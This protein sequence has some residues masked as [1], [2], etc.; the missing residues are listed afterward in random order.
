MAVPV[1]KLTE[2]ILALPADER[3]LLADRLVES[4]DPLTDDAVRGSWASEAARRRDEVRS[5]K[6][7]AISGEAAA[8]QVRALLRK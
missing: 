3:A 8:E 6:V 1:E 7:T 4:L 5:G 2:E